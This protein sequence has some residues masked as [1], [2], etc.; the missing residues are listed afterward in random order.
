MTKKIIGITTTTP[1]N[2]SKFVADVVPEWA[3][4]PEKPTYT[5]E[6]VGAATPKYVDDLFAKVAENSGGNSVFVQ[7]EE[8]ADVKN[9]DIWIDTDEE[10][11]KL[12]TED[13]MHSYVNN[14][15]EQQSDSLVFVQPDEPIDAEDG[16]LWL[17]TDEPG[18]ALVTEEQMYSHTDRLFKQ[19]LEHD[20]AVYTQPDE[21]IGAKDGAIWID[22]DA[23][24]E[25]FV[26]EE[27]LKSYVDGAIQ[28]NTSVLEETDPTVPEWAK[29]P[30]K[31][32]YT[33]EEVGAATTEY[34]DNKFNQAAEYYVPTY[35][36]H[37][38]P[39]DA[40]V[41]SI[42]YDT[43][44]ELP[45]DEKIVTEDKMQEYVSNAL[46]EF[47]VSEADKTEIA[48]QAAAMVD[49]ALLDLIGSGEV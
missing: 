9:G 32:S 30:T 14:L 26:T 4:Q 15:L 21:P 25:K 49:V 34:V 36:Q 10:G 28:N 12:V 8:P 37:E 13:Q 6:E 48:Q 2:P 38:E 24:E 18:E 16:A 47:T 20:A 19:A 27:Q 3:K 44:D 23:E 7:D 42:W 11:E 17:D 43:D 31:P 22:T 35:I 46:S 5:A 33:A 40:P 1:L 39:A 45:Q 29:Q 41:G